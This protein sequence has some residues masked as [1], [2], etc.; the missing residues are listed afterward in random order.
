MI[1]AEMCLGLDGIMSKQAV[2]AIAAALEV[3][4]EGEEPG[5][6]ALSM[7]IRGRRERRLF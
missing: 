5:H 3:A 6:P 1:R 4:A 7:E 2:F